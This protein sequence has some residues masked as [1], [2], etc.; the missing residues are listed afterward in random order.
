MPKLDVFETTLHKSYEW[1]N[2]LNKLLGWDDSQRSYLALRATL[3][4]LRDRLP[5]DNGAKFSSQLPM[6]IRGFYYESWEPSI[7]PVKA[8]TAD[9]F[10]S[11]VERHLAGTNLAL[12]EDLEKI[13][14]AVFLVVTNH[15]SIGE[16]YHIKQALPESIASLFPSIEFSEELENEIKHY[17]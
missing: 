10:L 4:V 5:I 8:R 13:V 7:T 11:L 17:G 15:V 3:H 9:E 14:R 16:I 2:E 6:L 1:L 12:E